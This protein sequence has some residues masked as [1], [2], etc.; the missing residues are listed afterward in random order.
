MTRKQLIGL[1][2]ILFAIVAGVML[3]TRPQTFDIPKT[4]ASPQA[5][6]LAWTPQPEP[7]ELITPSLPTEEKPQRFRLPDIKIYQKETQVHSRGIPPV[8]KTFSRMFA[9]EMQ[10]AKTSPAYARALFAEF[11]VCALTEGALPVARAMCVINAK[12]L[13]ALG[14][15][16]NSYAALLTTLPR[17]VASLVQAMSA[18]E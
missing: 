12:R 1:F 6:P 10:K 13:V 14:A 3:F 9:A 15:D 17:D 18:E 7:G 2:G 4:G 8:L 16:Q 11:R 5:P